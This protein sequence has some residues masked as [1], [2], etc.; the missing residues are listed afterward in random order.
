MSTDWR[1]GLRFGRARPM[2][3]KYKKI[4]VERIFIWTFHKINCSSFRSINN[5][6]SFLTS[7]IIRVTLEI[8]KSGRNFNK[9]KLPKEK[10]Y[11][12]RPPL[13]SLNKPWQR[14]IK[15]FTQRCCLHQSLN[16]YNN[17]DN[18]FRPAFLISARIINRL[19]FALWR[20]NLLTNAKC[21]RGCI[22]EARDMFRA[23]L[24]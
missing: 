19:T 22:R 17:R 10:S 12:F 21:I 3:T 11:I 4:F 9:K 15:V 24:R 20:K 1:Y 7:T 16:I 8:P 18:A 5:Y 23:E 2:I 14:T 13:R 6:H